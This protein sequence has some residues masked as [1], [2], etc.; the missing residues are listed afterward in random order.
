MLNV[1]LDRHHPHYAMSALALGAQ[2]LWVS[3]QAGEPGDR[4]RLRIN[5]ADVSLV[6]E[7]PRASSIRNILAVSVV[8][9]LEVE[10]QVDVKL[11]LEGDPVGAD[12]PWARDDLGLAPGQRLYAQIKSVSINQ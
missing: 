7:V 10:G 4:L 2:C 11:A 5:A 12:H 9:L 1:R 3:R 8:E 6:R